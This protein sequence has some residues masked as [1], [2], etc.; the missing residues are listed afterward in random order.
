MD[1]FTH[2]DLLNANGS[3]VA[4]GHKASF[5]L[6]DTDCHE[7]VSKR[8]ECANFGDQ[9]ITVGCWDLYR[10]DIDCQWLDITDVKPGNYIMQ[11]VIN[12]NYEVAES[13]FTNNAMKCN[14]K[15]DGHRI[16]LHNCHLGDAFS[17]EAERRFE[18]YPGQINNRIS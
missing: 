12:P 3:K 9:G 15:Y 5:C 11:V 2:Y 10:H 16:W 13:D 4:E 8:Y 1:I 17:E 7:G 18:K 6:E 14:C